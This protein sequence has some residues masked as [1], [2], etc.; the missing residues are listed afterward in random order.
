MVVSEYRLSALMHVGKL[1][2]GCEL[3][4]P[5]TR[6]ARILVLSLQEVFNAGCDRL[7]DAVVQV[8]AIVGPPAVIVISTS[9]KNPG[10]QD[11]DKWGILQP[12]NPESDYA[13]AVL[14]RFQMVSAADGERLLAI[15]PNYIVTLTNG[16]R[17]RFYRRPR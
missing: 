8:N 3:T 17:A 2:A 9:V 4:W 11:E 12:A 1:S 10:Y 5:I 13:R 6:D 14:T 7:S 15:P 16:T